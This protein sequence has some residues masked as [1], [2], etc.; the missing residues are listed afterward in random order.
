MPFGRFPCDTVPVRE[1]IRVGLSTSVMQRGKTGIARYVV[2]LVDSLLDSAE[3]DLTIFALKADLPMLEF[4]AER[5]S[6][7]PVS[8]R[9]RAPARDIIWHQTVLPRLARQHR[10]DVLHVPSYRRMLGPRPCATVATIHDLAPFHIKGKYD[11]KRMLYARFFVRHLARRQSRII[12]ISQSTADDICRFF[13]VALDRLTVIYNG[14]DHERFRPADS[15]E[16]RASVAER[17]GIAAPFFLYVARLEHPGKNHV[18]LIDAFTRFKAQ[19]QSPWKLAFAGS[20]WHGANV[21]HNAIKQ[22][23]YGSDIQSLGFVPDSELPALYAAAGAFVY[24]SLFEGFGLPPVEAMA[25]GCPV[26]CSTRGALGEVV[27]DAAL[28][29][30]PEDAKQ[31]AEGLSRIATDAG[32]IERLQSAGIRRAQQ[33]TWTACAR[34]TIDVYARAANQFAPVS[35]TFDRPA[36]SRT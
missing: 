27:Q 13:G 7:V 34:S 15:K 11:W 21:I 25:C 8:E 33:F 26:L 16:A 18:R 5:A 22:S 14:I 6:I 20:D 2:S 1:R 24:P 32:L 12:A 35:R 28:T 10:L 3:I 36:P 29:I 4:A 9:F 23:P 30:D 17:Y 19:T 31:I